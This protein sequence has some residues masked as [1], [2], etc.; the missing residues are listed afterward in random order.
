MA[1]YPE[2]GIYGKAFN[3]NQIPTNQI[4]HI[5]YAFMLPNP[6]QADYDLW[7][8]N[9]AFPAK[10][11]TPPPTVPEGTLVAQDKYA[12]D[13][14]IAALKTLKSQNPNIKVIIS[15]GG[16]SMSFNF[17]TVF[18][19]STLRN[20][21]VTSAVN[22]VVSNG[23]DGIDIDWE[24]PG[25]QGIGFNHVSPNDPANL[26]LAL[27]ELRAEFIRKSPSK[28]YILAIAL[29]TSQDVIASHKNVHPYVDFINAMTYDYAGA[30]GNGGHLAGLYYNPVAK[31]MDPQWNASSAIKNILNIGCPANKIN[32]GLPL[33]ARGW[34][35]IIPYDKSLP[36]FGTSVAGPATTYSGAAGEPGLTD[37]KDMVKVI[38]T[39]G[40]TQ[41]YDSVAKAYFTHNST[42]G[43]TWS[44]DT[45]ESIATK[46]Q[47]SLDSKLAGIFVWE[48]TE[49]T[50]DGVKNLLT[51]AVTVLNSAD[52]NTNNL[53][54]ALELTQTSVS[55]GT[56][57]ITITNNGA[58]QTNWSFALTTNNF[59][60]SALNPFVL[61]GTGNNITISAPI[62]QPVLGTGQTLEG[63]FVF[64]GS[65][66]FSVT[67]TSSEVTTML[68][69]I[70]YV[71]PVTYDLTVTLQSTQSWTGNPSGGN[72][73]ITIT[74][75][76]NSPINN[77]SFKLTTNFIIKNFW[78]LTMTGA[79][80]SIIVG[81]P[82][83][84]SVLGAKQSITSGFEYI[85]STF[86]TATSTTPGVKVIIIPNNNGNNSGPLNFRVAI[87]STQFWGTGGNGQISITNN[88]TTPITNWSFGLTTN[89]F[90]IDS[91]WSLSMTKT[92]NGITV[93][94]PLWSQTIN[95]GATLTSGFGYTANSSI[96]SASTATP[97]VVLVL[98]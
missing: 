44:F 84:N 90:T 35:K 6:S 34:K 5:L 60:I 42:S 56:G 51:T 10:P 63:T 43:E 23:F 24:Y 22:F 97:G 58:A 16:W 96:L 67:T 50:R 94:P 4:T 53:V 54:V 77:W 71:P 46:T 7:K 59:V 82:A 49:D 92:S 61:T 64:T 85:G 15:V 79:G 45:P 57:K 80:N 78:V 20:N 76:T 31:D 52:T 21:F 87:K 72:G 68:S 73:T 75:N 74:N 55:N 66:N 29:G 95:A 27:R 8:A 93:G 89:N 9:W 1:Y 28:T 62:N 47:Y 88:G 33:Y 70:P 32:L 17:S 2:W 48:I 3:V 41:Y 91:L 19:N 36:L 65:N 81:P 25:K 39:N 37:W 38:N 98:N 86:T 12:N 30:W 26:A 13:I 40:H 14:N 11:Y 83:W 69:V 18:A